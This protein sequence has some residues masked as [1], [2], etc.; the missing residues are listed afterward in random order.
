VQK[1]GVTSTTEK[2]RRRHVEA[3]SG[4]ILRNTY[5]ILG[6]VAQNSVVGKGY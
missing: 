2:K 6:E 4:K 5:Q 1:R 3:V